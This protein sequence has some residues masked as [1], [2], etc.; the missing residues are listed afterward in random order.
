MTITLEPATAGDAESLADLRLLA[1]RESLERVQR[2][3]P[4]R[5]RQRLLNN[6]AA[7][8]TRHVVA[9][10]Q[11]VGLV[12]VRPHEEEWLLDHLYLHPQHQRQGIGAAVMGLVFAEADRAGKRLR[13]GALKE[14]AANAF[15]RRHGFRL[16]EQAEWDNYYVREP[17]R[18]R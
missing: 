6:F 9:D 1:M 10:G 3:D 12:V 8:H 15:Y 13:V 4:Q 5:A 18:G 17:D 14:S 11:R 2:F 16:V 7:A